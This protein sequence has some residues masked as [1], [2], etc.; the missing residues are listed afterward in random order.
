M[1]QVTPLDDSGLPSA[2]TYSW[3]SDDWGQLGVGATG[4]GTPTPVDQP[5]PSRSPTESISC[6]P[7]PAAPTS[8]ALT[9]AGQIDAW[10]ADDEGQLGDGST[11][12]SD[13]PITPIPLP[14]WLSRRWPPGVVTVW[15]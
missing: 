6:R 2:T 5:A 7:P 14:A 13:S 11:T 3:G 1:S 9:T 10:G 12:D 8:S 15:P 4:A